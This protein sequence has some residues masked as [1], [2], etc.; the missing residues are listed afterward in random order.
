METKKK[1][2]KKTT[3]KTVRRER[4]KVTPM[5]TP[6]GS[7]NFSSLKVTDC[8]LMNGSLWMKTKNSYSQSAVSL[9]TGLRENNLCGR[10]VIP[11]KVEI[12]W[13]KL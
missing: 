11:V 4:T 12:K 6:E 9:I 10:M 1:T 2:K 3:K 5:L 8:F 13:E 7:V